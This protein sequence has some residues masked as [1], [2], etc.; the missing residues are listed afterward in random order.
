[1]YVQTLAGKCLCRSEWAMH[2]P[3]NVFFGVS[4]AEPRRKP[5]QTVAGSHNK[6][7]AAVLDD[8]PASL[9][10]GNHRAFGLFPFGWPYRSDP[11]LRRKLLR[12]F[13]HFRPEPFMDVAAVLGLRLPFALFLLPQVT[14]GEYHGLFGC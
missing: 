14:V 2:F 12:S 4:Y 8:K 10:N 1:M 11:G 3:I 5:G 6:V 9:A 7:F 13:S